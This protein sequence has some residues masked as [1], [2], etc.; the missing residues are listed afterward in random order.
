[1]IIKKKNSAGSNCIG[2]EKY[3][4][5]KDVCLKMYRCERSISCS[6]HSPLGKETPQYPITRRIGAWTSLE[7]I[8]LHSAGN[9]IQDDLAHVA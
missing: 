5:I 6:C 4:T 1:M 7:Q 2:I 8:S 9:Q 3:W